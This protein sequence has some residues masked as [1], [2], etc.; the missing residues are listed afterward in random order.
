ML[1]VS[2]PRRRVLA[3]PEPGGFGGV[4]NG[5]YAT[6]KPGGRLRLL[7]P[8]RL[9]HT[10]HVVHGDVAHVFE[11]KRTSIDVEGHLPLRA[12]LSV[13]PRCLVPLDI[14]VRQGPKRAV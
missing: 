7:K 13:P 8:N 1:E 12:V 2:P 11:A 9:K 4:K 5:F 3:G 6:T 14:G 10:P